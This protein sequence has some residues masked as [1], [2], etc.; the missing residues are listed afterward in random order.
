[1]EWFVA[2]DRGHYLNF[3]VEITLSSQRPDAIIWSVKSK[4]FQIV[5]L[6]MTFK[7][8]IDWAHERK[9]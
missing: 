5:K 7:G 1:M 4:K 3:A 9:L 2:V 8:T 6:T